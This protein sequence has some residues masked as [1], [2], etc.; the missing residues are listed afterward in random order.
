MSKLIVVV[1]PIGNVGDLTKRVVNFLHGHKTFLAEDTR[2]FVALLKYIGIESKSKSIDSFHDYSRDK[3]SKIVG[4][5]KQGESIAV[6]SNA[7]SPILSDPA[8]PLVRKAI[9]EGCEV[10]VLP[11]VNSV[12]TALELSGLP[13]HP[14]TFHGFLPR[15]E[16]DLGRFFGKHRGGTHVVFESP[17]R[18]VNS[19]TILCREIPDCDICVVRELTK[20]FEE[21]VRF[22][23]SCPDWIERLTL[24]G[25]HVLLYHCKEEPLSKDSK[26]VEL[27]E[28]VLRKN[29]PKNLARLLGRILERDSKDV[30]QELSCR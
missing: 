26:T 23:A 28:N 12:T 30:Y 5:L 10:E 9:G 29:S 13:P 21:V 14:F 27:A 17:R 18:I 22:H 7:G 6:V 15:K 2:H 25:E 4:R 16:G 19:I 3:A 24:K 1:L 11:G 20:K 8:Y